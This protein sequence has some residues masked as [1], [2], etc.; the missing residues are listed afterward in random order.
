MTFGEARRLLRRF[1]VVGDELRARVNAWG[2]RMPDGFTLSLPAQDFDALWFG[3]AH[4]KVW[5][6]ELDDE[7]EVIPGKG[8]YSRQNFHFVMPGEPREHLRFKGVPVFREE[9]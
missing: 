2:F 3:M 4:M 6:P 5:V 9:A 8:R 7:Q 1:R